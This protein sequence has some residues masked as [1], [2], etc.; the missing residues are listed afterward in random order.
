MSDSNPRHIAMSSSPTE[1][2][3]ADDFARDLLAGLNAVRKQIPCKY[4]YDAEGSALFEHICALPEYYLARTELALLARHADEFAALVG[5]DAELVEFGAGSGRKVR[6]LLDAVVRPR[7]YLPIDISGDCLL[8]SSARIDADYPDLIVKPVIADFSRPLALPPVTR[9][10]RR[11]I[12]FFPGS[13]IGNF[14]PEA[15]LRFLRNAARLFRG[16]GLLVGVDLVK[17]PAVLHAAYNDVVGVTAAFNKNLLARADRELG[18]D[19]DLSRFHHHACY[20]PLLQRI[21]MYLVSAARQQVRIAGHVVSFV[22]GEGVH[23][24]NSHKMTIEG[25]RSLAAKAGF[26]PRAMWCD[27]QRL[28]SLHWLEAN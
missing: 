16:G 19:F 21:E 10:A 3:D 18:A 5:A 20:N 17:D 14:T 9:G 12:G 7:A 22:E 28:F 15:T 1:G 23:T 2:G 4:F 25:F 27:V 6:L 26:A 11:R 8:A 24:E 13:T